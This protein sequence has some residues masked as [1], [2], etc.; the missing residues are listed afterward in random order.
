VVEKAARATRTYLVLD[1]GGNVD[2]TLGVGN[3]KVGGDR[4]SRVRQ[5]R[6]GERQQHGAQERS[7]TT[8]RHYCCGRK[9]RRKSTDGALQRL[10]CDET[11]KC[12][13]ASRAKFADGYDGGETKD[14]GIPQI[15]PTLFCYDETYTGKTNVA[16]G[17]YVEIFSLQTRSHPLPLPLPSLACL[18]SVIFSTP[19]WFSEIKLFSSRRF[20]TELFCNEFLT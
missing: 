15:Y 3:N 2:L 8:R 17:V 19:E 14:N 7:K 11:K 5:H 4:D 1:V 16:A 9:Q 6:A 18:R 13:S 10:W 12:L 20:K